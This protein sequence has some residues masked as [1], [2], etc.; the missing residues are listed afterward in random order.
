MASPEV[1]EIGAKSNDTLLNPGDTE[2]QTLES[3]E[4]IE[5]QAFS[6][7]KAWIEDKIKFLEQLPP[8]Q[9]FVGV[10]A[11]RTSA[12]PVPGLPSREQLQEW[13]AE[14]DRI[15]KETEIFDSGELKK[16][17]KFTKAATQRHLSPD[18]TDLIELTLTAIYELDKLLHL[19]R[20]RSEHLDLLGVRL[21]WEEHRAA[22]WA[23]LKKLLADIETLL[24]TRAR[25]SSSIYEAMAKHEERPSPRRGSIASMASD[26]STTSGAGFSRT[27][28]FRLAELLSR[29]AAQFAGKAS[30]LR[31]GR[32]AVAGKALDRLIDNSRKPVPEELLDEQD[33][34]EEKGIHEMENVGKFVMDTVMQWRK[35]DELYVETMKDQNAAQN[36]LEEIE[37]A[38]LYH[39]T[40]RQS[41]SFTSRP[42]H[43]SSANSPIIPDQLSFNDALVQSLSTEIA[44]AVE[45][46]TKVDSL[47]K[48]YRANYEAV[49]EVDLVSQ[50][51]N[52]LLSKFNSIIDRLS[53]GISTYDG[54]GSPPDLS[55]EA[56]LQ[57][58]M[59]AT[60]LALLPPLLEEAEEAMSTA[61][62]LVSTIK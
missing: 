61:N 53:N 28:R 32:I 62:K 49:R 60:Y 27:A 20:D 59:H 51:T 12:D 11:V 6:E 10:D 50:S 7:R 33:R 2:K 43:S 1:S 17:R 47:A 14:H 22:A 56:C 29:D 58:T 37:T 45:L 13:L 25:W 40:S 5:L 31:H 38:K 39:P 41:S 3:H 30:S 42:R 15:E 35:A 55:S 24:A 23:D 44:S 54:D 36:L 19:L 16:L 9:V 26:T 8:I 21:S 52:E 57:P 34:L 46:V 4:V 48:E 18:D